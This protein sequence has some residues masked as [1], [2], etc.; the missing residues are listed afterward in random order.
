VVEAA[1]HI[2]FMSRCGPSSP[3]RALKD[4][5]LLLFQGWMRDITSHDSIS[6]S[7]TSRLS[8]QLYAVEGNSGELGCDLLDGDLSKAHLG[9][10]GTE[11]RRAKLLLTVTAKLGSQIVEQ[12]ALRIN[13]YSFAVQV[14]RWPRIHS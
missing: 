9:W 2:C 5:A 12:L 14:T 3:L 10:F 4:L 13:H 8:T 1:E 11:H 6:W 7:T